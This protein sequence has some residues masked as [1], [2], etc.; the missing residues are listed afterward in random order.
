[1][2][3]EMLRCQK[4]ESKTI[5]LKPCCVQRWCLVRSIVKRPCAKWLLPGIRWTARPE[6]S[7]PA[8]KWSYRTKTLPAERIF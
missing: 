5:T 1:M 2:R 4:N 7:I 6:R 8:A 3:G